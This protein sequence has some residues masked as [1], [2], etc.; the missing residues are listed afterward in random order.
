MEDWEDTLKQ[1]E[2]L[3]NEYEELIDEMHSNELEQ[4]TY[5]LEFELE[6]NE[7]DTEWYDFLNEQIGDDF[8]QAVSIM[9]LITEKI[10]IAND[11]INL[12]KQSVT[13]LMENIENDPNRSL[14]TGYL[15]DG[16]L[17][18]E[19]AKILKDAYSGIIEQLNVLA[20]AKTAAEELL[21]SIFE[22]YKER[23]DLDTTALE[24]YTSLLEHFGNVVDIV[25]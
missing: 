22:G 2:E 13:D 8:T 1:L 12:Y 6:L 16:V 23:I 7:L 21:V 17:T 24:H 5:K 4:I 3:N 19:E 14:I 18:D 11:D 20:E 15:E 10:K 25:G 9:D